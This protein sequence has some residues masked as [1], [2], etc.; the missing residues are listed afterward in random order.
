M[1]NLPATR[2]AEVSLLGSQINNQ[3][4]LNLELNPRVEPTWIVCPSAVLESS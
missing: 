3:D 4:Y 2:G 1:I